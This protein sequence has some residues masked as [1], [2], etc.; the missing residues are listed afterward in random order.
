MAQSEQAACGCVDGGPGIAQV[1]LGLIVVAEKPVERHTKLIA[2]LPGFQEIECS[3]RPPHP[4][5]HTET[6]EPHVGPAFA[7]GHMGSLMILLKHLHDAVGLSLV[8][9]LQRQSVA[10]GP[11]ASFTLEPGE[12]C[13]ARPPAARIAHGGLR[14]ARSGQQFLI[15]GVDGQCVGLVGF[16]SCRQQQGEQQHDGFLH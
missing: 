1:S 7:H 2:Q 13:A 14:N 11:S 4:V 15:D 6:F 3:G 16:H 10:H 5:E 9:P 8:H 12:V